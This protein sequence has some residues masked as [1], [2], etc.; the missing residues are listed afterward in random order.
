MAKRQDPIVAM[1]ESLQTLFSDPIANQHL[2]ETEIAE[3]SR[4][5]MQARELIDE[6]L[7]WL[8]ALQIAIQANRVKWLQQE[9]EKQGRGK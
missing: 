9:V 2:I 7:Q 3:R 5:L 1:T 4:S 8:G 6:N